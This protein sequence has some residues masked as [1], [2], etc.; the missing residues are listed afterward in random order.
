MYAVI[1][2]GG[3]GKRFWPRSRRETPK[4]LLDIVSDKSMLK[5]TYERLQS[6]ADKKKIFIV[7]GQDFY[8]PILNELDGFP[9]KNMILEPTGKSTAPCIGLAATVI[10]AKDPDAVMG[11]FPADHIIHAVDAFSQAVTS[12]VKY[13]RD[14]V[15]LVTFGVPP[16]RPATGYG[17]IQFEKKSV[18]A[19]GMVHRVK[20]F[21]EKP[22]LNTAKRFL[23]SGE[24]LWN[25]GMFIWKAA[26]IL[27]AIKLF[28]PELYESLKNIDKAI[29]TSAYEQV[30]NREWALI[31]SNSIDYGVMEKARN[32]HVVRGQFDWSDVGSWEAVYELKDKN[33]EGNVLLGKVRTIDTSGSY[34]FSDR[35]MIA[36]V[37]IRDMIIIQSGNSILIVNRNDS[38]RVKEIVELLEHDAEENY[39]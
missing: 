16:I 7:A 30:L 5:L 23:E 26:N 24:F 2:A 37:G 15:S 13:A 31:Q 17:Y 4:Q 29:G 34:I 33:S 10:N 9:E 1:M 12:G 21:A 3:V 20:T 19:D 11:V 6:V 27:N 32:V 18:S 38:E 36:T 35:N 39:L 25:S 8:G 28:L 22:N 14:H